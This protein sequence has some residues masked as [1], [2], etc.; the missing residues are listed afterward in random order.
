MSKKFAKKVLLIGWDA[1]DWKIINPLLDAGKLP[2][3]E[4][5]VNNGVIGN[6]ATLNP[7]LSP[8]L[9]TSISTG[10]R[11]DKHG[12][13][14]FVEPDP[15]GGIR[16]VNVTSR[17]TR[18]LWNMFH[19]QGLKSNVVGWWPSHPAEPINGVMVSNY[20]EKAKGKLGEP[21]PLAKGTI[22]PEEIKKEISD[23][24]VHPGEITA[25]HILPFIPEAA[26]IDQ[27]KDK[28]MAALA[29]IIA[30][31]SSIQAVS[32]WLMENTEWDFMAVYF[33]A[34]DHFCHSF[35]KMHPP[36]IKGVDDEIFN[37]YKNVVSGGYIFQ[38]MMLERMID[39]AGEDTTIIIVSDHGFHSDHLRPLKLPK[40][41]AAPALEHSPY[42]MI[43]MA[44]PNIIKDERIYGATLLDIAPTILNMMGMPLGKDMD[45]KV[46]SSAFEKI[47]MPEYIDSWDDID[48]DFGTHPEH[49]HE[50]TYEAAE[51]LQQLVDLG[52]IEDPGED[53]TKSV[54]RAVIESKYNLSQ[55]HI[56]ARKYTEAKEILEELHSKDPEDIRFSM[57]LANCYLNCKLFDE[58]RSIID[59]LRLMDNKSIPSIDLMEGILYVHQNLPGK[60]LEFLKKAEK[61]N[62]RIPSLHIELGKIYLKT[63][64][65]ED[66]INAYKKAIEIDDTSSYAYHGIAICLLRQGR[67][68]EAAE[69]ALNSINLLY[70]FPPAH[71]HLGEALFMMKRYEDSANAFEICLAMAPHLIK[72]RRWLL[73]IYEEKL[74]NNELLKKHKDMIEKQIKGYVTIVSGLPRSG[75]SM[76]MQMLNAGGMELLT[77]DKRIADEN[78][79]KGY[80]EL[81]EVKSLTKDN[82]FIENAK[83]KAVKV[84]SHLLQFLPNDYEYRVIFM[85][86]DMNEILQSQQKMLGKKEKVYPA[87]IANAFKKEL[88]KIDVLVNKEPNI[89]LMKVNYRNI[90]E[91]PGE[92]IEKINE[93]LNNVLDTD[94]MIA[95]VE[96]DLY[97]NKS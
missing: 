11:A 3:L 57:E 89:K 14:D 94:K 26:K 1:A 88:E 44:G 47:E 93:F 15:H 18:A 68:E 28:R 75:T 73:K 43:C 53:K 22:F 31:A 27:E 7:P 60:A 86:R 72:A 83:G 36:Q 70:H 50:D 74:N 32:T 76:M 48:G 82:S 78:N 8:I 96:P 34:I 9:W 21:W 52:Y 16:P 13:L 38:D 97:R 5:L 49:M 4:K 80:Y 41:H 84:I 37:I 51:A 25:S 56:G 24:R 45:G 10:K 90:I 20:F 35:M 59:K 12:I 19:N 64:R 81:E 2:A 61:S 92:N 95:E 6:L 55:V 91:K 29:K 79:P 40:F 66:S 85:E 69:E 30:E 46:L 39:L 67:Y 42:G 17:K 87:A 62:P 54:E 65:Y 23:L 58:T 33:D 63:Q 77:D 71:Y